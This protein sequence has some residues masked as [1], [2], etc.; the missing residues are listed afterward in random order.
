[1][2]W[3]ISLGIGNI[4]QSVEQSARIN[5]P[6]EEPRKPYAC[7]F[8]RPGGRDGEEYASLIEPALRRLAEHGRRET[9][10]DLIVPL[11]LEAW[12]L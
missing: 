7:L 9:P 2:P 4:L 1:V 12:G 11:V 10:S 6:F 3:P 5:D 8:P